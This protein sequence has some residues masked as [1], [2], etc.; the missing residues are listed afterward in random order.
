MVLLEPA[1]YLQPLLFLKNSCLQV[2]TIKMTNPKT[3]YID[4]TAT[5]YSGLNTGIQR[6]VNNVISRAD[7]LSRKFNVEI[8]PVVAASG[9]FKKYIDMPVFIRHKTLQ[10]KARQIF[11]TAN[12]RITNLLWEA[13]ASSSPLVAL[14]QN[15]YVS[16]S[17]RVT[18]QLRWFMFQ[19][20]LLHQNG[21]FAN[22]KAIVK[23]KH[24]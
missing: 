12:Q 10:P 20:R 24:N 14:L 11:F 16:N 8:I 1:G 15:I 5:Y 4:C 3:I 23:K 19:W 9:G 22:I 2:S 13:S 21:I 18:A 7:D 6:V 17:W